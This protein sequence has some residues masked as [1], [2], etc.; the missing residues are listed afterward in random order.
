[1]NIPE[2]LSQTIKRGRQ[3]HSALAR[4]TSAVHVMLGSNLRRWFW[5]QTWASAES[6]HPC[7]NTVSQHHS[8]L[9]LSSPKW[10]LLLEKQVCIAKHFL[11]FFLW[12]SRIT[13]WSKADSLLLEWER[14]YINRRSKTSSHAIKARCAVWVLAACTAS[15]CCQLTWEK[16]S[17]IFRR[18]LHLWDAHK[19]GSGVSL[20]FSMLAVRKKTK[21]NFLLVSCWGLLQGDTKEIALIFYFFFFKVAF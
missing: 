1:M 21:A 15:F 14:K 17:L 8:I 20:H 18:I 9:C 4:N 6:L 7:V 16:C 13:G 5:P 2:I 12:A 10:K 3:K 11:L 19:L